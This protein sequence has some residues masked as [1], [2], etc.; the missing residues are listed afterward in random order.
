M[1]ET[2]VLLIL[3]IDPTNDGYRL[4]VRGGSY[5]L[6]ASQLPDGFANNWRGYELVETLTPTANPV[7]S[8]AV[9]Q[10]RRKGAKNG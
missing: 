8:N 1:A 7:V 6:A 10:V 2:N 9:V 3:G 5:D 4:H